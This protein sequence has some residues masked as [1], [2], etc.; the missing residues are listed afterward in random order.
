MTKKLVGK[1]IFFDL[2]APFHLFVYNAHSSFKVHDKVNCP[3]NVYCFILCLFLLLLLFH[4]KTNLERKKKKLYQVST[5]LQK[6]TLNK[7]Y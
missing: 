1:F 3:L 7:S 6:L 2:F 5:F 4:F